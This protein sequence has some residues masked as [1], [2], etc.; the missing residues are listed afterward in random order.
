M[1]CYQDNNNFTTSSGNPYK[2]KLDKELQQKLI[3]ETDPRKQL[4]ILIE[5]PFWKIRR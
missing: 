2:N 1:N 5:L 4:H 3:T